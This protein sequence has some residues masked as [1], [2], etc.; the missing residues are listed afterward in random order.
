MI[1]EQSDD[2]ESKQQLISDSERDIDQQQIESNDI[3]Q[4]EMIEV[5]PGNTSRYEPQLPEIS[6]DSVIEPETQTFID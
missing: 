1:N 2:E 5:R 4:C 6:S 3:V